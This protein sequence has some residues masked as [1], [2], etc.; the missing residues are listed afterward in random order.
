MNCPK[1]GTYLPDGAIFCTGCGEQM[2]EAMSVADTSVPLQLEPTSVSSSAYPSQSESGDLRSWAAT[3]TSSADSQAKAQQ[4]IDAVSSAKTGPGV[5]KKKAKKGKF[6]I[7]AMALI[8]AFAVG[9]CALLVGSEPG[10]GESDS[11]N[12]P[13]TEIETPPTEAGEPSD[14]NSSSSSIGELGD[15]RFTPPKGWDYDLAI[16]YRTMSYYRDDTWGNIMVWAPE[17]TS[18]YF[19][20]EQSM[21]A[22]LKYKE[23]QDDTEVLGSKVF[24]ID[25]CPATCIE[26]VVSEEDSESYHMDIEMLTPSGSVVDVWCSC[27]N[28]SEDV[29][30]QIS[31]FVDTISFS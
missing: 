12:T 22:S 9:R 23:G 3:D 8:L 10:G 30:Q 1:C 16:G 29:K 31:S 19:D 5:A 2:V 28:D 13:P 7:A 18:E 20:L 24:E 25:G 21:D 15:V 11:A 27:P 4:A 6:V 14:G 17:E 26:S